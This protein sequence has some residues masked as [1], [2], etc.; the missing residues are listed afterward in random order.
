MARLLGIDIGSSAVKACVFDEAGRQLESGRVDC[1]SAGEFDPQ[2]WIEGCEAALRQVDLADVVAA[3]VC[4][5][6][7]TNVLLDAR[8]EVLGPSWSDNRHGELAKQVRAEHPELSP[9]ALNMLA[10]AEWWRREHPPAATVMS[11]KD[12]V[13]RWLT[14]EVATDPASGG[15]EACSPLV[16]IRAPWDLLGRSL[17]ER[18]LA[19]GTPVATGWHDGAAATFGAGAAEAGTAPVT[20]GTHA[21]FRVVTRALPPPLR[22]YWDLT[23]G[24]TVT[25]GDIL[26]GGLAH[27]WAKQLLPAADA[28]NAARGCRGVLFLPQLQGRIAPDARRDVF[29][30]WHGL[31][32]ETTAHDLLG[33][34][35]EGV[36]FALRQVRDWLAENGLV[37]TRVVAT[38]GGAHNPVQAGILA[39]VLGIPVE[40]ADVEEGCRGAALLGAVAAGLI[41]LDA[42]RTLRPATT[43]YEPMDTFVYDA[44]FERWKRLQAATDTVGPA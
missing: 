8:G 19:A 13:G 10:K 35:S 9:Q 31:T 25:G 7:G 6:G 36:A 38:G 14:G 27:A 2:R 4:G 11:A 37:A 34:V 16:P 42:A 43:T 41:D 26:A 39:G 28:R 33:A 3:G 1:P 22:K 29:G 15:A 44:P 20:L 24:L 32:A 18:P 40:V 21:V 5:R 12:Y 30:T 23:P 17:P